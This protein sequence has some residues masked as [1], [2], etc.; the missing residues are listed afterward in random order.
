MYKQL[1][2]GS[3]V[4][5]NGHIVLFSIERFVEDIC[6]GNRCFICGADPKVVTFNDEHVLPDWILRK[7]DLHSRLITLPNAVCLKYG[8]Y[9]IPCCQSCNTRMSVTFEAPISQILEGGYEA[10]VQHLQTQGPWLLFKWLTLI[11][12][13]THL[14][15]KFLRYHLDERKGRETIDQLYAWTELHHIHCVARS[16]FSGAVMDDA[17]L[18]SFYA[19]P[20]KLSDHYESFDYRDLHDG[21]TILLSLGNTCLIA[22]LND[23]GIA[24]H[25]FQSQFERITGPLSPIQLREVMGNMAY[26]NTLI[27]TRPRYGSLVTWDDRYTIYAEVPNSVELNKY[28]QHGFGEMLYACTADLLGKF[29]NPDIEAIKRNV[30]AGQHTFLFDRDGTFLS[31]S[32]EPV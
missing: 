23:A 18:G 9:K 26:I 30:R 6:E 27:K 5:Q 2:D 19:L 25:Y 13:K 20:A 4:G 15:D 11:F 31:N 14:K 29:R 16:F 7:Y 28:E 17:V 10:V 21:R 3:V 1:A 22:V 32:M 12:L 24:R 8:Q